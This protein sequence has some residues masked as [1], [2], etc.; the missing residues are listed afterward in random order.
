MSQTADTATAPPEPRGPFN[1][2]WGGHDST[3]PERVLDWFDERIWANHRICTNCFA[4]IKQFQT[5]TRDHWGNE[6]TDEWRTTT[7]TL[8]HAHGNDL[9]DPPHTTCEDCGSVRGLSQ[10]DTLS[11]ADMVDRVPAL[12]DRLEEA[13]H[14][15]AVGVVYDAVRELASDED[16]EANDKEIFAVAAGLGV[17]RT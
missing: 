7:A 13:G 17:E 2:A 14:Q 5:I 6:D 1:P 3:D 11:E 9:P 8:E 10:Y 12:V 4:R 16:W 15:V